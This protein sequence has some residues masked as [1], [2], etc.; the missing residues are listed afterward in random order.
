MLARMVL[1]RLP[2]KFTGSTFNFLFGSVW[3]S[4]KASIAPTTIMNVSWSADHRV[5]D[6]ATIARFSNSWKG[7]LETPTLML[8]SLR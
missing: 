8:G 7:Y 5:I 6:G 1:K 2:M 4:G 3:G